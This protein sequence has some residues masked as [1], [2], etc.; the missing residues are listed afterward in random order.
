M[1]IKHLIISIIIA[2]SLSACLEGSSNY[3]PDLALATPFVI[4]GDSLSIYYTDNGLVMDTIHIGDTVQFLVAMTAYTNNLTAFYLK[5]SAD[6]V[7]RVILPRKTSLDS[8]FNSQ[9]NYQVG[10]FKIDKGIAQL[11]FPFQY[12]ATKKSNEAK[13][14]M[15]VESDAK[16]DNGMLAGNNSN[17]KSII[18]RTPIAE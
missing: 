3:A 8:I 11:Y 6:S 16:F 15:A 14:E 10:I 17:Y 12:I 5:Q 2:T 9:S 13:I 4:G 7:S 1:K 18:I